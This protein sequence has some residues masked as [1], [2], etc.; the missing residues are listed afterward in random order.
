[1]TQLACEMG[2]DECPA[3]CRDNGEEKDEDE[4]VKSGDLDVEASG[5]SNG[6]IFI[7]RES[8]L[9][10]ISL[11]SSEEVTITKIVLERIGYSTKDNIATV[12]LENDK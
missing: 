9:D 4:V 11:K 5:S 1:M 12:K 6:R 10:T 8:E 2:S 7:G 3:A